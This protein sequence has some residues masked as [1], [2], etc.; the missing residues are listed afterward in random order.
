M[1]RADDRAR[2][3]GDVPDPPVPVGEGVDS[4]GDGVADTVVTADGS[5][6][7]VHVDLD[8]D[9]FADTVLGVGPDGALDGA[10]PGTAVT[11]LLR[12]TELGDATGP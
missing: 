4:D 7:L 8:G 5:G 2:R 3:P 1:W 6:L 10:G 12:G 11:A 9:G